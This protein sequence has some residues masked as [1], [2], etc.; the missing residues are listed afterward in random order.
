[1]RSSP[2]FARRSKRSPRR[3]WC[4]TSSTPASPERERQMAAVRSVLEEVGAAEVPTVA[5]Y[6]KIDAITPDE[7]RRLQE[8]DPSAAL[9]FARHREGCRRAAADD[10]LATGARHAARHDH[11]RQRQG[12]R[13]SADRSP[14]S[15]RARHQPRRDEWQGGHRGG[16]SSTVYRTTDQHGCRRCQGSPITWPSS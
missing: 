6:N 9:D 13:S 12:I 8:A 16:R 15:R 7:R 11:V 10:G 4:C 3:I 1:M 2:R 5:V 14:V